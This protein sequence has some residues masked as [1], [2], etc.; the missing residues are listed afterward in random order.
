MVS[1]VNTTKLALD[2]ENVV[3]HSIFLLLVA[4]EKLEGTHLNRRR[5]FNDDV[6][7][8][9][10]KV[11]YCISGCVASTSMEQ[12][13]SNE[14]F[15]G[16]DFY[17]DQED[18]KTQNQQQMQA[19]QD[20]MHS[21][22]YFLIDTEETSKSVNNGT[23]PKSVGEMFISPENIVT[24]GKCIDQTAKNLK[25]SLQPFFSRKRSRESTSLS[26]SPEKRA[27]HPDHAQSHEQSSNS[28]YDTAVATYRQLRNS[29]PLLTDAAH[30]FDA[31]SSTSMFLPQSSSHQ[32]SLRRD[33]QYDNSPAIGPLV[34]SAPPGRGRRKT[35][36]VINTPL[37]SHL[38]EAL[39]K[40]RRGSKVSPLD[41]FGL[42]R[43]FRVL[44]IDDS[45]ITLKLTAKRL[46]GAGFII[47]TTDDCRR[48]ISM[49]TSSEAQQYDLVLTDLNMPIMSGT[50]VETGYIR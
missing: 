43:P 41:G 29:I 32:E 48:A 49:M 15:L 38:S 11:L 17:E 33:D 23:I 6:S 47:D 12:F 27:R 14:E 26:S 50:E 13:E 20:S 24:L 45:L 28:V 30:D 40:I 25:T 3:L 19:C 46:Q 9:N 21:T 44:F 8:F 31:V 7:D 1:T 34:R 42:F 36:S 22:T 39:A 4:F 37:P 5:P 16:N 35:L 18:L 2:V 10:Y